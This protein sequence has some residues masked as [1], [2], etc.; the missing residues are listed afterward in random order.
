MFMKLRNLV[1]FS[2]HNAKRKEE[3]SCKF[4]AVKEFM[5]SSGTHVNY[6]DRK[7][8]DLFKHCLSPLASSVF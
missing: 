4:M 2:R 5:L 3:R 8:K 7:L 1:Y 6:Q